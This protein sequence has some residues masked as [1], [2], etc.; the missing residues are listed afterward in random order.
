MIW[1]DE[2]RKG[3]VYR[4]RRQAKQKEKFNTSTCW[5]ARP[6][7]SFPQT[8]CSRPEHAVTAQR[9]VGKEESVSISCS[10][11]LWYSP[12]GSLSDFRARKKHFYSESNIEKED[13]LK[14]LAPNWVPHIW[15][16]CPTILEQ[17]ASNL[18]A[19]ASNLEA[20]ACNLRAIA[21]NPIGMASNLEAMAS[22]LIQYWTG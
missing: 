13:R 3:K 14:S 5:G 6:L 18:L 15:R 7:V 20:M 21:S 19:M 17:M 2:N 11:V 8:A 4:L 16:H 10:L 1:Q 22:N 12:K 9:M